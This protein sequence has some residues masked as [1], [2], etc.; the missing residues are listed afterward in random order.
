MILFD[1]IVEAIINIEKN[2]G[3]T[4]KQYIS[5]FNHTMFL[6]AKN[7]IKDPSYCFVWKYPIYFYPYEEIIRIRLNDLILEIKFDDIISNNLD[8]NVLIY[9]RILL[10]EI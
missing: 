9:G 1:V 2:Y 8:Y 5:V 4:P 10:E 6:R 3:R 7:R